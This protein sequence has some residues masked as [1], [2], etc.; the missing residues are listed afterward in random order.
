MR[1]KAYSV[2]YLECGL[3]NLAF[4]L[5]FAV[6]YLKM[7]LEEFW[8]KFLNSPICDKFMRG[9][10][11][12]LAGRSGAEMALDVL[13]LDLP[14]P[15]TY[16]KKE[17]SKEFW[18]GYYLAYYQ[19]TTNID[20]RFLNKYVS[21]AEMLQMYD[22]Y[23]DKNVTRFVEYITKELNER[24]KYTNLEI[25][26]RKL[27]ISRAKLSKRSHVPLRTIEKYEQR[28]ININRGSAEYVISLAKD[29]Y[30][31]PEALLEVY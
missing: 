18:L 11:T 14:N 6:N 16:I 25:F 20:F 9:D 3:N 21:I 2:L 26:R 7:P 15:I 13:D 22:S 5:D 4:C 10:S 30:V 19:W 12:T 31:K 28:V 23:H 1:I 24:K 8:E 29:L 27:G 17:N